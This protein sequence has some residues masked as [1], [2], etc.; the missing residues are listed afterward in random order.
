M[1]VNNKDDAHDNVT[2]EYI[3]NNT[4]YLDITGK[5]VPE[6]ME[7]STTS[8]NGLKGDVN[9]DGIVDIV[10]V[11]TTV[12]VIVKKKVSVFIFENGD[13]NKDGIIDVVDLME[14]VY[15]TLH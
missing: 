11:L 13:I 6:E 4:C 1:A 9:N 3:A 5:D 8:G 12:N 14:I 2:L 10:D 15:I 7:I